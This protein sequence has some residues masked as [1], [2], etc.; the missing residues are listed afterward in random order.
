MRR[1][2][3]SV[4]GAGVLLTSIMVAAQSGPAFASSPVTYAG[5][6]IG[7]TGTIAGTNLTYADTL[8][9]PSTG[10]TQG[11]D[12]LSGGLP[13]LLAADSLHAATVGQ[14]D[15]TR[16]EAS[17]GGLSL[18][19]GA[20]TVTA[21]FAMSQTMA[22]TGG[23]PALSGTVD[24]SG[25]VVNGSPVVVTGQPNQTITLPDGQ[26]VL[27]EQQISSTGG[28]STITMTALHLVI[29]GTADVRVAPSAAGVSSGSN[30][31]SSGTAP[32]TG[33]G[34]ILT[35]GKG[36]FGVNG[37]ATAGTPPAAGHV[38]FVDHATGLKVHGPVTAYTVGGNFASMTGPAEVNGQ[39]AGTFTVNVQDNGKG[40][41][42]F[43]SIST[44]GVPP[45]SAAGTL[46]GGNIQI[47]KPC[48]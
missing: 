30:N 19:V 11:A 2:L 21:D 24:L 48:K 46:Q 3:L 26:L 4:V 16:S 17:L 28:V 31:C 37:R 33:G 8:A 43:F 9:L 32:T 5:R 42:D 20:D 13:G 36:T 40:T 23:T 39:P 47:H 1:R 12:E 34:W 45:V 29:S 22:V 41:T 6:G 10:G 14:G 7:L 25:L 15:R 44:D 38:T 18:A 27:T 35:T